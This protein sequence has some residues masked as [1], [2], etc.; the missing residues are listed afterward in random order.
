MEN[1]HLYECKML[2]SL[3][4]EVPYLKIFSGQIIDMSI[5]IEN[6]TKHEYFIQAQDIIPLS[7]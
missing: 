6:K 5:L 1:S 3:E 2:N 4:K 7:H